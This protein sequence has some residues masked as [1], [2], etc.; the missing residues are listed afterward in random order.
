ME[1]FEPRGIAFDSNGNLWISDYTTS[2]IYNT[3]IT[4]QNILNSD[5]LQ[6]DPIILLSAV[7]AIVI[8]LHF[9]KKVRLS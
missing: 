8:I 7:I 3:T 5:E 6:Y 4:T 9:R 1:G 2:I